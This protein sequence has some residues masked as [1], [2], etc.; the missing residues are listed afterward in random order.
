MRLVCSRTGVVVVLLIAACAGL[1]V[2][3]FLNLRD[4]KLGFEPTSVAAARVSLP[5]ASYGS[6]DRERAFFDALL[7]RLRATSGVQAAGIVTS[8]PFACCAPSTV[9]INPAEPPAPGA[10]PTSVSIRYADSSYYSAL[11][12]PL[13][14]GRDRR[15]A[16]AG[17]DPLRL[18]FRDPARA[19]GTTVTPRPRLRSTR[20]KA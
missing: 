6:H 18:S 1:M 10:E 12:I 19:P 9:A 5:S 17:A 16:R 11:G 8:R 2:R 3:S 14:T 20:R 15:S 13:L 4:V 7:E